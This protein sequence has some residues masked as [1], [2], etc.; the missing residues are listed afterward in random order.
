MNYLTDNLSFITYNFPNTVIIIVGPTAVGKTTFAIR[1]AQLLNTKIISADS[2]QCYKELSIGVAKPDEAALNAVHHYF[3]NSHSVHE[4]VNAAVFEKY[5]LQCAEAIF[6]QN[7]IAVM[8][9]GTGLYIKAFCEGIDAMPVVPAFVRENIIRQYNENG[10]SWLQ[11]Q[12]QTKDPAFWQTAERQNPQRLMRALEVVMATE[13]SI[14]TFKQH[15][16]AKRPFNI[17][18]IGLQLPREQLNINIHKRVDLMMQQGL[19]N[20]VAALTSWQYLNALQ[21]VGYTELFNYFN[22][23]TTLNKAIEQIKTN[24]RHYAKRQMTWFRKDESVEW[25]NAA[26]ANVAEIATNIVK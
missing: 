10:L 23:K 19:L 3:I 9:G 11:H 1:L 22:N 4:E 26:A 17:I 16:K 12:V 2:R 15:Q 6:Q 18:K 25:Y 8:V 24:T 21:T 13:K 14:T 7:N 20:E 5:A